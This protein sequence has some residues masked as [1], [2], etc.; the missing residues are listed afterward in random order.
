MLKINFPRVLFT[1]LQLILY[2]ICYKICNIYIIIDLHINKHP[3]TTPHTQ[4]YIN[5]FFFSQIDNIVSGE[6]VYLRFELCNQVI[7]RIEEI[8][9]NQMNNLVA[10]KKTEKSSKKLLLRL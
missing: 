3:Q 6:K 5:F 9:F 8:I 2:K 10:R 1:I 4:I 7:I